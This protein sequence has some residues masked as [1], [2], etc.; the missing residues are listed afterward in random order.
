MHFNAN[1]GQVILAD[2][3][4]F[5]VFNKRGF[6]L[7]S[8]N[9]E[10]TFVYF[11]SAPTA[12]N[13]VTWWAIGLTKTHIIIADISHSY[14]KIPRHTK[15][16]ETV[17]YSNYKFGYMQSNKQ[18]DKVPVI[19]SLNYSNYAANKY[20]GE[21]ELLKSTYFSDCFRFRQLAKDERYKREDSWQGHTASVFESA[22][23][24]VKDRDTIIIDGTKYLPM[25]GELANDICF[26]TDGLTLYVLHQ[27][28]KV[29]IIDV[30]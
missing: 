10:P 21:R 13:K 2:E 16:F 26:S 28:G 29:T 19:R 25:P 22:K 1:G 15:E 14:Y 18:L 5:Y 11:D 20:Q 4:Y 8:A 3:E 24:M 12:N 7:C 23:G 17:D 9:S 6:Y 27:A 30:D